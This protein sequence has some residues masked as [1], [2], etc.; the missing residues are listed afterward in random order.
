MLLRFLL[1]LCVLLPFF[2][3]CSHDDGIKVPV[4]S[5]CQRAARLE[6]FTTAPVKCSGKDQD[7]DGIDDAADLCPLYPETANNEFD[8]DGCPDPDADQDYVVDYQDACPRTP[9]E[10]PDGCPMRDAD[11]DGIADHLDSCP[12][13]REDIDGEFDQ[14]G[15]PEG[16]HIYANTIEGITVYRAE[17]FLFNY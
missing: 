2:G 11:Q 7:K 8:L 10:I 12:L 4:D 1:T 9:G 5:M 6:G 14:D 16:A 17:T 3:G 13:Q 15:C